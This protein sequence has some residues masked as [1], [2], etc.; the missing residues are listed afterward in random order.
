MTP[1]KILWAS[2]ANV[3]HADREIAALRRSLEDMLKGM[4]SVQRCEHTRTWDKLVSEPEGLVDTYWYEV[5]ELFRRP[6]RGPAPSMGTLTVA[7]SLWREEDM[8]EG[9]WIGARQA[10]LYVGFD[11]GRFKAD[12]YWVDDLC[13]DGSGSPL[14]EGMVAV[15]P[16]LWEHDPK[17]SG[18]P[19][20]SRS[21]FFCVPL[22]AINSSE[23]LSREIVSPLDRILGGDAPERAFSETKDVFRSVA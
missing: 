12:Q 8:V 21:W 10:K 4:K 2:V 6:T 7:Y 11:P 5:Y 1:S 23:D 22:D 9:S 14:N 3:V 18:V 13:L 15:A 20:T 17:P 19:L 16:C